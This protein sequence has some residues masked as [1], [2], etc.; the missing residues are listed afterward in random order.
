MQQKN[1]DRKQINDREKSKQ[2][3]NLIN[4]SPVI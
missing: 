4:K 3:E 1:N 2:T